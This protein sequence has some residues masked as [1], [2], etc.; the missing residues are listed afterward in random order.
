MAFSYSL[1]INGT[2]YNLKEFVDSSTL[3]IVKPFCSTSK[4]SGKGT[5]SV[6]I[7]GAADK[8][9]YQAFMQ[10]LL[11]YAAQTKKINDCPI[12]VRQ[13]GTVV[14]S[15]FLNKTNIDI[16]SKKIPENLVLSGIDR[17]YLLDRKIRIN[18]YWENQSRNTI[19]NDLFSVLGHR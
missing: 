6:T 14:F 8:T 3:S 1:V 9:A 12:K 17:S 19:I 18:R 10:D 4:M 2:D 13:N 5:M 16:T 15:G 7:K 11:I